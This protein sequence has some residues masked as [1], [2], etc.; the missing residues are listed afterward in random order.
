MNIKELKDICQKCKKTGL[1]AYIEKNGQS[2]G[3]ERLS[4]IRINISDIATKLNK[5]DYFRL[6]DLINELQVTANLQGYKNG[7]EVIRNGKYKT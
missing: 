3:K 5:K 2:N 6:F 7:Q 4:K 1:I